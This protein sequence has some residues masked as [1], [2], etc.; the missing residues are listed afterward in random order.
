[1]AR[2]KLFGTPSEQSQNDEGRS[3]ASGKAPM[4]SMSKL[5]TTDVLIGPVVGGSWDSYFDGKQPFSVQELRAILPLSLATVMDPEKHPHKW[6]SPDD[7]PEIVG[8]W[9][10][11]QREILFKAMSING[12]ADIMAV[13]RRVCASA[14][15]PLEENPSLAEMICGLIKEQATM[16]GNLPTTPFG[17]LIYYGFR[18][19]DRVE[20]ICL[21]CREPLRPDKEARWSVMR[22]GHYVLRHR[23]CNSGGPIY[24]VRLGQES[25]VV[26]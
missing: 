1:M 12:A 8:T 17:D 22:L 4:I 19:F 23:R 21:S 6:E 11:R 25:R 10:A 13:Y 15:G 16:I 5:T 20:T 24:S 26:S 2:R 9:F 3:N 7:F 18:P 14:K